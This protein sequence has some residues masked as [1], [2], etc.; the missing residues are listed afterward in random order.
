MLCEQ[1]A[2]QARG[3]GSANALRQQYAWHIYDKQG[4]QLSK[5]GTYWKLHLESSQQLDHMQLL[6]C[7]LNMQ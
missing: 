6:Y 2:F 4:C 3:A 1:R 5:W 7:T